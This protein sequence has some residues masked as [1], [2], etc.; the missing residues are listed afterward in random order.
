MTVSTYHEKN[1]P[2]PVAPDVPTT[3][4]SPAAATGQPG[5]AGAGSAGAPGS[6]A[7]A[8]ATTDPQLG[9]FTEELPETIEESIDAFAAASMAAQHR[10]AFRSTITLPDAPDS[11]P[12]LYGDAH[13]PV[14]YA[15]LRMLISNWYPEDISKALLERTGVAVSVTVVEQYKD[16]IPD[17]YFLAPDYL[18][19]KFN[20]IIPDIDPMAELQRV[21]GL[22]RERLGAASMLETFER[23]P[24]ASTNAIAESFF[25]MLRDTIKLQQSLGT[26]PTAQGF[27]QSTAPSAPAGIQQ[28]GFP[29]LRLIVEQRREALAPPPPV[30]PAVAGAGPSAAVVDATFMV[31]QPSNEDTLDEAKPD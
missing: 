21:L 16:L 13:R 4:V 12:E 26:Q 20:G 28:G 10:R 29:T 6:A 22:Q 25:H 1:I 2:C 15:I 9:E 14:R 17:D 18:V 31:L 3:P 27:E 8:T 5:G 30:P 7:T 19:E 24:L 11:M 23:E